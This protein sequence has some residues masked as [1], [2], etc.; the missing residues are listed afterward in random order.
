MP[1]SSP[2]NAPAEGGA[3]AQDGAKA[4]AS[5]ILLDEAAIVA[6]M[7]GIVL[8]YVAEPG[9]HVSSGDPIVVLEAMKMENTLPSPTDGT[10]KSLPLQ[11]GTTVAKDDILA[12]IARAQKSSP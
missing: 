3:G 1:P 12:V 8:R 10:V 9:Q 11:P 5:A 2:F 6:P 7:P 4:A